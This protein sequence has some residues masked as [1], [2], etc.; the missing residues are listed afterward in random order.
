MKIAE[1]YKGASESTKAEVVNYAEDILLKIIEK[2]IDST[3]ENV[4]VNELAKKM[5][6]KFPVLGETD[7]RDEIA[8]KYSQILL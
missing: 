2:Y 7:I 3:K 5:V 4:K 8:E 6:D 1:L